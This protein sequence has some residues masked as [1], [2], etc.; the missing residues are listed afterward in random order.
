MS[1]KSGP[2]PSLRSVRGPNKP[3]ALSRSS[4]PWRGDSGREGAQGSAVLFVSLSWLPAQVGS[5]SRQG[6]PGLAPDLLA[7]WLQA[8]RG[9][10]CGVPPNLT[11]SFAVGG[12]NPQTGDHGVRGRE[13]TRPRAC[14]FHPR[15]PPILLLR[16]VWERPVSARACAPHLCTVPGSVPAQATPRCPRPLGRSATHSPG[17][18]RGLPQGHRDGGV[19]PGSQP[20]PV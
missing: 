20:W 9:R 13:I 15:L 3:P 4:Q 2:G 17:A 16:L 12:S 11:K 1:Q 19:E 7:V 5:P 10:V 8:S 6:D 18:V 14:P